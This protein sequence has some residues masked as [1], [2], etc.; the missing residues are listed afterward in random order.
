MQ[1]SETVSRTAPSA[2]GSEP[3]V[4]LSKLFITVPDIS[5]ETLTAQLNREYDIQEPEKLDDP[6]VCKADTTS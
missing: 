4:V 6:A 1:I 5:S 2:F 3:F